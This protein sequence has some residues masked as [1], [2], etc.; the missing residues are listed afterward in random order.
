MTCAAC[1]WLGRVIGWPRQ[2]PISRSTLLF[3]GT[4]RYVDIRRAKEELGFSPGIGYR[5][6]LAEAFRSIEEGKREDLALQEGLQKRI[7][8][9]NL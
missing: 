3:L 5:E 8:T 4:S 2:G 7:P 9:G 6:G 1:E